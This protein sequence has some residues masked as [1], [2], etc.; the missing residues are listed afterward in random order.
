MVRKSKRCPH[1]LAD[2]CVLDNYE[3]CVFSSR[4]AYSPPLT[5]FFFSMKRV[6]AAWRV[7][8]GVWAPKK[9]EYSLTALAQYTATPVPPANEWITGNTRAAGSGVASEPPVSPHPY[10]ARRPRSGRVMRHVLRARAEAVRSLASF[11]A[12]LEAG[13]A[14]KRVRASVHLARVYGGV[15]NS[16]GPSDTSSTIVAPPAVVGWRHAREVV[17]YLRAHDAK[18][19]TLERG[20]EVEWAAQNS[21]GDLSSA[22]DRDPASPRR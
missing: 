6:A 13:P 2:L 14:E 7:L 3:Q 17:A 18:I 21:D 11:I 1:A 19:A 10:R 8:I 15:E 22:E 5:R 12:Q 16:M 9:W 20:I 4:S